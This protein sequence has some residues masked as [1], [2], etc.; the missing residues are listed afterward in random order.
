MGRPLMPQR[1]HNQGPVIF[2]APLAMRA[3][4]VLASILRGAGAVL[5]VDAAG[6]GAGL[7]LTAFITKKKGLD[8][9]MNMKKN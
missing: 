4:M 5:D 1:K 6:V 8:K 3:C 7:L 9:K 2:S